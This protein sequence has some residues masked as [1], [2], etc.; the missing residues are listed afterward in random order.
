MD[1]NHADRGCAGIGGG[2][3][4]ML[5][6]SLGADSATQKLIAEC[7]SVL[8][9]GAGLTNQLL[10]MSSFRNRRPTTLSLEE[11]LERTANVAKRL[12]APRIRVVLTLGEGLQ[13]VHQVRGE[14]E[15]VLLNLVLNAKQAMPDGGTLDIRAQLHPELSEHALVEVVDSGYGMPPEIL[16]R[17]FEPFFTTRSGGDG[18][19]LGLATVRRL[20]E[21]W[22]GGVELISATGEGTRC[23]LSVPF[24]NAMGEEPSRPLPHPSGS[25]SVLLLEPAL[26]VR[27]ALD[28]SLSAHGYSVIAC[29][30]VAE[31]TRALS[32]GKRVDVFVCT[33]SALS[34]SQPSVLGRV[35]R[36]ELCGTSVAAH[37][38]S[39]TR[40]TKPF[41]VAELL[42]AVR[43]TLDDTTVLAD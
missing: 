27:T 10:D 19:G 41:S 16:E 22:G 26:H 30:D 13:P 20:V 32:A 9:Q 6:L 29:A 43:R 37:D 14:L 18:S 3:F 34:E 35:P 15:Q 12:M 21:A 1:S 23:L 36:V 25:E 39:A 24:S 11:A 28:R 5:V 2:F 38:S 17:A 8:E 40:L 42:R 7:N 31:A 33:A 4:Y